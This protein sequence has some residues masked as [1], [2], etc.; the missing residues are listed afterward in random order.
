M[1]TDRPTIGDVARLAGV[2]KGTVSSAYSGR[3]P[4][5]Q[6]TRARI[7]QA[8]ETLRWHPSSPARALATARTETIG[9]V[10]ARNPQVIEADTFFARFIAGCETVL[11]PRHFGL[12]LHVVDNEAAE[13]CAYQ[14]L[15]AGRADGVILLDLS[16]HDR[17]LKLVHELGLPAVALGSGSHYEGKLHGASYVYCDDSE[18]MKQLVRLLARRGHTRIAH[19][20][21]PSRYVHTR[22]RRAAFTAEMEAQGLEPGILREGDFTSVSGREITAELLAQDQPPT[23]ICYSNDL[24]AIAGMSY[25]QHIGMLLP[26]DLSVT[27]FDDSDLAAQLSP[28]LT[29]VST[30]AHERGRVVA[31]VLLDMLAGRA[32]ISRGVGTT[33]V[34]ERDSISAP[35][36]P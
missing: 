15:A 20:S 35:R 16:A 19:V 33:R 27:G 11:A 31:E 30:G 25:A 32:P 3:R 28:P 8:A 5:S 26:R 18:P 34:V 7:F 2:S 23:A 24:M 9:L 12:A 22:A 17:R 4:V 29:S 6:D 13:D 36:R 21:G 10:L 1:P 14:R